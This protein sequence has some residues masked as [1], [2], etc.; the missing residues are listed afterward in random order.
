MA[1]RAFFILTKT[2]DTKKTELLGGVF[3]DA[4]GELIFLKSGTYTFLIKPEDADPSE[5]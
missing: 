2:N 4:L 3:L 5:G 1:H